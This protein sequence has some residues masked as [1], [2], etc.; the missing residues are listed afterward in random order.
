MHFDAFSHILIHFCTLKSTILV[1]PYAQFCK[2][3]SIFTVILFFTCLQIRIPSECILCYELRVY[4]KNLFLLS[5]VVIPNLQI[6][7][8]FIFF[9]EYFSVFTILVYK[10][11]L[12]G[13]LYH[14]NGW[15]PISWFHWDSTWAHKDCQK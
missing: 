4:Y 7:D 1:C 11:F 8:Y 10:N 9:P 14:L 2:G 12:G 13:G 6:S 15:P 5:A 3:H